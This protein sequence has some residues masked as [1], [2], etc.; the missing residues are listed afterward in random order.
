MR[1]MNI[2][3]LVVVVVDG[4]GGGL[5]SCWSESGRVEGLDAGGEGGE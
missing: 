1:V 4:D 5:A 3:G 2:F